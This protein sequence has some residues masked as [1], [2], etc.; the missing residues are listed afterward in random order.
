MLFK[1]LS[2]KKPLSVIFIVNDNI[3]LNKMSLLVR[4]KS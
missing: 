1:D 4:K 3:N 2:P